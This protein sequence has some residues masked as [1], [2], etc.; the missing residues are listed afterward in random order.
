MAMGIIAGSPI[1]TPI[2]SA[3][4]AGDVVASAA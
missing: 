4:S 1:S 2:S 3:R